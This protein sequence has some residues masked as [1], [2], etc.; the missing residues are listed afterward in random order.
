LSAYLRGEG[1][2]FERFKAV[3]RP[4]VMEC[5]AWLM[6]QVS[7]ITSWRK[8]LVFWRF[9]GPAAGWGEKSAGLVRNS[10]SSVA[11]RFLFCFSAKF[12]G[13]AVP[14][15]KEKLKSDQSVANRF[16]DWAV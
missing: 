15:G 9:C 7:F 16:L 3:R 5:A 6:Y 8:R 12:S 11:E 1:W 10:A 2:F 13:P 14:F 4:S